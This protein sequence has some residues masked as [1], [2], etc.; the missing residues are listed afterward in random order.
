MPPPDSSKKPLTADEK[1][2][3]SRWIEEGA[4]VRRLLGI[5]PASKNRHYPKSRTGDGV[6]SRSIDLY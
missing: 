4:A 2:I 1:D 6:S 5:R 3:I